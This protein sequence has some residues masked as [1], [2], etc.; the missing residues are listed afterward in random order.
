MNKIL[1]S[2]VLISIVLASCFHSRKI[3]KNVTVLDTLEVK[4]NTEENSYRASSTIAWQIEQST[5]AL[6]FDFKH[7]TARGLEMLKIHPYFYAS[8]SVVLDA[9]SMKINNVAIATYIN[10]TMPDAILFDTL[11]Y[12]LQALKF[13]YHNN[14]LCVYFNKTY[15]S[16]ENINI[17]ISYIAEPYAEQIGGSTAISQ[18]R[19]LY[20]INTDNSIA[21]KPVQIWTQ[22]E[23][24]SNSHWL[25]TVDKPNMRFLANIQLTVPDTMI[26]LSNG[27]LKG[28]SN[29]K[30]GTRTDVW[31]TDW[32]IQPYALMFAIGKFAIVRDSFH[33]KELN[34][35]VEPEYAPYARAMF[36]H[37]AQMMDYFGEVTGVPYPWNKYSHV[38]VRDYVS[39][40]MENTSATLYG[41]F[42]N[43]NFREVADKNYEDVVSHELFHQWFG[44]YVTAESWSNLTLNES[45]ANFG[46]QLWREHNYG[47]TAAD[48]IA[49]DD[50]QA[51]LAAA[52]Y[53]DPPLLR[54]YYNDKEQLFDRITYQ[55]GGAILRYLRNLCGADAFSEAMRL[56]L[57]KNALKGAEVANWRMALEEASGQDWNWFFN[58]WYVRGGH[59][60][61]YVKYTYDDSAQILK[62]HIKQIQQ[63]SSFAYNLPLRN[64]LYYGIDSVSI[65]WH[66][67]K[68]NEEYVYPYKNGV[69]PLLICDADHVLPGKI[70]ENKSSEE[71][72]RQFAL[73]KD[74]VNRKNCL[75]HAAKN[76]KDP[77]YSRMLKMALSQHLGYIREQAL[78]V[79]YQAQDSDLQTQYRSFVEQITVNDGDI[80]VKVA[81]LKL[82]GK[83]KNVLSKPIMEQYVYDSSYLVAG[84][85]LSALFEIDSTIA[86]VYAKKLAGTAPRSGLYNSI[87]YSLGKMAKPEDI[88][89][90]EKETTGYIPSA[91]RTGILSGLYYYLLNTKDSALFKA[92]VN[93]MRSVLQSEQIAAYKINEMM[94]LANVYS[95]EKKSLEAEKNTAMQAKSIHEIKKNFTREII[96]EIVKAEESSEVKKQM[97]EIVKD[98]D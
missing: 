73:G 83:W 35:Y 23:T 42:M 80:N 17:L 10:T 86:Y 62:V 25:P 5:V 53:N 27:Y 43:E 79:M 98:L 20:F 15:T 56:Y 68:R 51:Y 48:K 94:Y 1:I 14:K 9:K 8:D 91:K 93:M 29:N 46:E 18:D 64:V 58:E 63:D 70:S 31:E 47:K 2:L 4:A 59:P 12:K 7:K 71:I 55:K 50:L 95:S 21:G 90:F 84:S 97:N 44:D 81:A 36:N 45:F 41:E 54:Y 75:Q 3:I 32:K 34:Y 60:E 16:K 76:L 13:S 69:R 87:S 49:D 33:A 6:S 61:L 52:K 22:G 57:S 65:D 19:G 37:T 77:N 11:N 39:G 78:Q 40:A 85:A 74:Y 82:L 72:L 96:D 38:V 28:T 66:L 24:E 89:Y 67:K 88:V 92:G 30:N 26:T